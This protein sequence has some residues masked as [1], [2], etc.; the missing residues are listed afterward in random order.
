M[1]SED[2][3]V[4]PNTLITNIFLESSKSTSY[5]QNAFQ[6]FIPILQIGAV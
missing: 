4:Q 3:D 5:I 2:P 1:P 6:L